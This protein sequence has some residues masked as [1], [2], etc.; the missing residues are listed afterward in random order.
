M[1]H[2]AFA[3]QWSK[4][5]HVLSLH[6]KGSLNTSL[7]CGCPLCVGLSGAAF[8]AHWS[9]V[10]HVLS[11]ITKGSLN[12][13]PICDCRLCHT[14]GLSGAAFASLREGLKKRGFSLTQS[15]D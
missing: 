4:V 5:L 6:T 15:G 7:I 11:L 14:L 2:S 3:A 12:A 9:K 13:S 1:L 10:L 8:A